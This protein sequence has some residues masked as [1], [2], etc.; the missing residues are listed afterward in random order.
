[1]AVNKGTTLLLL[2]ALIS[3]GAAAYFTDSYIKGEVFSYQNKLDE[4]Y[5]KIQVVVPKVSLRTGDVLSYNNL[6]VR[7]M[8]G[9][10]VHKEAIRA[11][12]VES[13]LGFRL[14]S[15]LNSGEA[16]LTSH[17]AKKRGAGFS[18]L[19][20]NGNRALT[21]PVDIVSSMSG[22]L[23]PG[24]SIDLLATINDNGKRVT[25][26]LLSNVK[27]LATGNTIDEHG[28]ATEDGRYQTITLL[29]MPEDAAKITHAKEVGSLTVMLRSPNDNKV[30]FNKRISVNTILGRTV[31]NK[32]DSKAD[33]IIG[34]K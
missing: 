20:K 8:P 6:A 27:I 12:E 32:L 29:V 15:P 17:I 16:L 23:R 26:P 3:G 24:D 33:V 31:E 5:K 7:S 19:I 30:S 28:N 22:F 13:V 21:F 18:N 25:L 10:Y 9:N 2:G 1:M 11:E 14:I 34:G 4:K